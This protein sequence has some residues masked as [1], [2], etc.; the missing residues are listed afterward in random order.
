[1][2]SLIKARRFNVEMHAAGYCKIK[3]QVKIASDTQIEIVIASRHF[4][5][6]ARY[7]FLYQA[8]RNQQ[9]QSGVGS[10]AVSG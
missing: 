4:T 1:M 6:K 3:W 8:T 9:H 5:C 10:L 7:L 2:Q